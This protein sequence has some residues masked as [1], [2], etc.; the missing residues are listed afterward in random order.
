MGDPRCRQPVVA[1]PWLDHLVRFGQVDPE[2][3]AVQVVTSCRHRHLHRPAA[4]MR[5]I[6]LTAPKLQPSKACSLA[7]TAICQASHTSV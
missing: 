7:I 6:D 2:L 5:I 4:F 3:E 1:T